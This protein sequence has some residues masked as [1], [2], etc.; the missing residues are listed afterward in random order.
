MFEILEKVGIK[1]RERGT[2]HNLY[3]NQVAILRLL[4]KRTLAKN[5]HCG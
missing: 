3:K 4:E 1:Y 2:I 5:A